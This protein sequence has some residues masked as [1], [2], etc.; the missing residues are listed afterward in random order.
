MRTGYSVLSTQYSFSPL[1]RAQ[2]PAYIHTPSAGRRS[3]VLA[4]PCGVVRQ[5]TTCEARD[6]LATPSVHTE[7]RP[8]G[9][10]QSHEPGAYATGSVMSTEGTMH[11]RDRIRELR[12]VRAG[13]LQP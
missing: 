12:R 7:P 3:R 5:R 8:S 6:G 4:D 1:R 13:D 10:G 2:R 11:I 9:S